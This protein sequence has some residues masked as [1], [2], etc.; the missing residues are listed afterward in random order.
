MVDNDNSFAFSPIVAVELGVIPDPLVY[1][2][3]VRERLHFN[4]PDLRSYQLINA[5]GQVVL[6]GRQSGASYANL[7]QLAAGIYIL[8][9]ERKDGIQETRRIVKLE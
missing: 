3:P 8:Q 1:P 6:Q 4:L 2:N 7:E 5:L 9:I